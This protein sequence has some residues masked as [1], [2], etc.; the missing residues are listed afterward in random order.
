[1]TKKPAE[2]LSLTFNDKSVLVKDLAHALK[3]VDEENFPIIIE[4]L[5][6]I[7]A[8]NLVHVWGVVQGL[9][10]VVESDRTEVLRD[11]QTAIWREQQ[12]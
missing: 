7:S 12:K 8:G 2:L 11:A 6:K 4:F 1:M 3:D 5:N 10:K 9:K